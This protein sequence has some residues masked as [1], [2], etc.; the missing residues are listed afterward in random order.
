MKEDQPMDPETI[1]DLEMNSPTINLSVNKNLN[2]NMLKK[3]K[4]KPLRMFK[5]KKLKLKLLKK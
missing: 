2:K 5:N 4:I 3:F 1:T